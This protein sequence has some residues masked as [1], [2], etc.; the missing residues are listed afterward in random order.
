M[1]KLKNFILNLQAATF[2]AAHIPPVSL[3]SLAYHISLFPFNFLNLPIYCTTIGSNTLLF[4]VLC[5]S[6][7]LKLLIMK[8]ALTRN[9]F[10]FT[11]CIEKQFFFLLRT[12][13][14]FALHLWINI[15]KY[16]IAMLWVWMENWKGIWLND[17][18]CKLFLFVSMILFVI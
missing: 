13:I 16:E 15:M 2:S 7:K 10:L 3:Y 11:F 9:C 1:Q 5:C 14:Y 6:N 4:T 18:L 17:F 8:D 12:S